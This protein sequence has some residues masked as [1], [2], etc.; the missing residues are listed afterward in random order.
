MEFYFQNSFLKINPYLRQGVQIIKEALGILILAF[1][2]YFL[3]YAPFKNLKFLGLFFILF[4]LTQFLRKDSSKEDI[5]QSKDKIN[6]NDYLTKTAQNFLIKTITKA[7][8]LKISNFQ[9]FLLKELLKNKK[10]QNLFFRLGID[11][12]NFN[13][14]LLRNFRESSF[15]VRESSF[16]E[17]L[18]PILSSSFD[19]AKKL[20]YPHFNL[21]FVFYGLR[22]NSFPELN[23]FF[24]KFDLKKEYLLSGILMEIYSEKI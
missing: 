7:E 1:S 21:I 11:L 8:I 23:E 17:T 4:F 13:Q 18:I 19:L 22:I 14:E 16:E 6:L 10:I 20:N 5:R 15:P 3:F 24:E 12:Q 2:L 9:I